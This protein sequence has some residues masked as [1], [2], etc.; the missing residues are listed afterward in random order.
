MISGVETSL[1]SSEVKIG[2]AVAG[3]R[4]S[5][6]LLIQVLSTLAKSEI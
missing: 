5:A 6:V 1:D 4:F 3:K 2:T